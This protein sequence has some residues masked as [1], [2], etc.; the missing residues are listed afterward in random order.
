MIPLWLVGLGVVACLIA[1]LLLRRIGPG[2]RIA[3][4]LAGAPEVTVDEVAT[5][6]TGGQPYVRVHGRIASDEEFPD[7][8]DRP[9]VYRRR[10]LELATDASARHWRTLEDEVIAVPF[11]LEQRTAFVAVDADRLDDGLTVIVRE[12]VG[13]AA[14]APERVPA[15]TPPEMPLRHRVHQVSA[16]E[17]AFVAGAPRIGEDGTALLTAGDGRPLILTTLELPEAMRLL[18]A[19]NRRTVVAATVL[20]ALG[21]GLVALGVVLAVTFLIAPPALAAT[22]DPSPILGG[23][24][25]SGGEGAGLAGQPFLALIGVIA[26]GLLVAGLS[27]AYVRL[28]RDA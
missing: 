3:R 17:Q 5:A 22:P 23:D 8:M 28:R 7:E 13:T 25:R 20:L 4:L 19:G 12:S 27:T 18:A 26:L 1:G 6:A 10:R 21:L 2:F 9:L 16:V 14:D 24:T 15:G 11:G